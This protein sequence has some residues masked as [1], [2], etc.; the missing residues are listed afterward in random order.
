[1]TPM[2]HRYRSF[3]EAQR[4]LWRFETDAEYYRMLADLFHLGRRL[5][6]ST[7][8]AGVF[9]F[10]SIEDANIERTTPPKNQGKIF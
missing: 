3:E 5:A 8:P 2:I 9:R 1:M 7:R 10:H 6:S 4:A